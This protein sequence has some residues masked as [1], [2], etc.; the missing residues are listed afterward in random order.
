M[1]SSEADG[2]KKSLHHSKN[3][4]HLTFEIASRG[5]AL[6]GTLDELKSACSTK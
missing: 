4:A 1:A 5:A 3:K 2:V 6:S